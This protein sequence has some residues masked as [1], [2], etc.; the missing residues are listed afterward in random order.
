MCS[1]FIHK[2]DVN[3]LKNLAIISYR[4][5][6]PYMSEFQHSEKRFTLPIKITNQDY[7]NILLNFNNGYCVK[8]GNIK[9]CDIRQNQTI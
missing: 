8:C 3:K 4:M 7:K 9:N 1:R 2:I 5:A 6:D